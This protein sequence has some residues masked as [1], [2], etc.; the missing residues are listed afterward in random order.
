MGVTKLWDENDEFV[1]GLGAG[2]KPWLGVR[3]VSDVN[4]E[5]GSATV[6]GARLKFNHIVKTERDHGAGGIPSNNIIVN[7]QFGNVDTNSEA[8]PA[9][10]LAQLPKPFGEGIINFQDVPFFEKI[11]ESTDPLHHDSHGLVFDGTNG[12]KVLQAPISP[13]EEI[14]EILPG[15]DG[16]VHNMP[17]LTGN[18]ISMAFLCKLDNNAIGAPEG[19]GRGLT[20]LTNNTT[21][22][23]PRI[24]VG[25]PRD[26][27]DSGTEKK[28]EIEWFKNNNSILTSLTDNDPSAWSIL[29][30][31]F[32]NTNRDDTPGVDYESNMYLD[33]VSDCGACALS[34]NTPADGDRG[35]AA[36][37]IVGNWGSDEC[38]ASDCT[39][40]TDGIVGLIN[41]AWLIGSEDGTH[42]LDE[43]KIDP[44]I[45][46]TGF[47]TSGVEDL[48]ELDP[49]AISGTM[50]EF[51][52]NVK[53]YGTVLQMPVGASYRVRAR[54]SEIE[55]DQEDGPVW[56]PWTASFTTSQIDTAIPGAPT[57]RYQQ[58]QL[59]VVPSSGGM[60]EESPWFEFISFNAGIA[61][62]RAVVEDIEIEVPPISTEGS[63]WATTHS[64][65]IVFD[66]VTSSTL[67]RG[68]VSDDIALADVPSFIGDQVPGAIIDGIT[69][70]DATTSTLTVN[71]AFCIF[72]DSTGTAYSW[73][74]KTEDPVAG[75]NL[76]ELNA[77]AVA[78]GGSQEALV[79]AFIQ[80]IND[81]AGA[82][83]V[84]AIAV[85]EGDGFIIRW[86]E[87]PA[88]IARD[89]IL[90]VGAAGVE[91]DCIV[92]KPCFYNPIISPCDFVA[93]LLTP[94]LT[95]PEGGEVFNLGTVNITWDKNDPPGQDRTIDEIDVTYEIEYTDNYLGSNTNWY[96]LKR[97]I[98]WEDT[99]YAWNVGKMIKSGSVR[100]RLRARSFDG[101][102][103]SEYS[104]SGGPFSI[105]VFDLI[106][107]AIVNPVPDTL[108][109]DFVLIIL[110]ETLTKNTYHQK[111]RYTLEYSSH[112][113]DLDWTLIIKDVPVG[114]NVI[115]WDLEALSP[116]NDYVL[117]LTAQNVC[118]EPDA[119]TPDQKAVSYVYN[120]RV[121]QSGAFIID[122]KPPE[123]VLEIENN[124]QI[125]NQ[126]DQIVNI[127][128]EDAT[129]GIEQI[130][131][132]ECNASSSLSLGDR[133]EPEEDSE[134]PSLEE[135]L[136]G[137]P[138]FDFLIGKPQGHATKALWKFEDI[139]GL[140]KL[141]A[142]LSDVGG[143]TSLQESI[144]IFIAVFS[145]EI[146]ITDFIIVIENR[147][148]VTI[149]DSASPP[150]I[151]IETKEFEVVYLSTANGQFWVLEP[152]PSLVYTITGSPLITKLFKFSGTIYL[153]TYN[154]VTGV[155]TAYRNDIVDATSIF[156]FTSSFSRVRAVA[157]FA[158][159]MYV[160]LSN[161][162]LW[163][164][165]GI[166]FV[167]LKLFGDPISTLFGDE[168]YLYIGF[169]SSSDIVLYDGT[170]FFTSDL[171][172]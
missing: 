164:F 81:N 14:Q 13:F 146:E 131:I 29:F 4:V 104:M 51:S 15:W 45:F 151:V 130:Q 26:V 108:Y 9:N 101:E 150:V 119:S 27:G 85:P 70:D 39:V 159:A 19:D 63:I 145:S 117:R 155:G 32:R 94:Q 17:P 102:L 80:S 139:S 22:G 24:R 114:Q 65:D 74:I 125:T 55:F 100:V 41:Q 1:D 103:T 128:A 47:M 93:A 43:T 10:A 2:H 75:L 8:S 109:T 160:G 166:S 127:F 67:H 162:E 156:T 60:Q 16:G 69:F 126:L 153:F 30:F 165:D 58:L 73:S 71:K 31:T 120:I 113:R 132:R 78:A 163:K 6:V 56:E 40:D 52:V 53:T 158:A 98:P 79:E 57:G 140:R 72:G 134:C 7:W 49:E 135:L 161:G 44:F 95:S 25:S 48:Q 96:V 54:A 59:E 46:K 11:L 38:V 90:S 62:G 42:V 84:S 154:L 92:D 167:L 143:N 76:I 107:P 142:L 106:A 20:A 171:E 111:V 169:E 36:S 35:D 168:S 50:I 157:E 138:D 91:P 21:S 105:N 110:D 121:Q 18:N 118:T 5:P 133:E 28:W 37:W 147:E 82:S 86:E 12:V 170:S 148:K 83:G 112:D 149:D 123:A 77:P 116:S 34:F 33:G 66:D 64:D 89:F 137:D 87:Q 124:T 122:T 129:T 141:E 23:I 115:R 144:K 152:F 97:R 61:Y 172:G 88:Q 3:V 68:D 99:S 136:T